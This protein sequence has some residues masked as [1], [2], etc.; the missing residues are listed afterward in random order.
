MGKNAKVTFH[1][2]FC[3]TADD[4]GSNIEVF[5]KVY[6]RTQ[7]QTN[8]LWDVQDGDGVNIAPQSVY[9]PGQP[10]TTI[11]VHDNEAL[12]LGARLF[13]EDDFE[14][15]KF[16]GREKRVELFDI[17]SAEKYFPVPLVEVDGGSR[18]RVDF[19]VV[20]DH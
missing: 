10:K 19:T 2:I 5:G 18:I 7:S 1:G 3:Q 13:E 9:L 14:N 8:V 20:E 16:D 11:T 17:N 4:A 12:F 15:D 6:A